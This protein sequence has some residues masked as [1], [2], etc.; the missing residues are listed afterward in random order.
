MVYA[1][2]KAYHFEKQN[3]IYDATSWWDGPNYSVH[4]ANA[5]ETWAQGNGVDWWFYVEV[6]VD[7]GKG[8]R[9]RIDSAQFAVGLQVRST[10]K[11]A[12]PAQQGKPAQYPIESQLYVRDIAWLGN[13]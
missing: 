2:P 8:E 5:N 1:V 9:R 12:K 3:T 11:Q 4:P 10:G 6:W 7:C 13:P